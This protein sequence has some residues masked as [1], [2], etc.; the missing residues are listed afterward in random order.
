MERRQSG[1]KRSPEAWEELGSTPH[2]PPLHSFA[3][4]APALGVPSSPARV[5]GSHQRPCPVVRGSAC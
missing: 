2:I 1:L 5:R 3:S 4:A